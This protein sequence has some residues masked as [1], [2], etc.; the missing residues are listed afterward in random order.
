MNAQQAG[1]L[2]AAR[3]LFSGA[4]LSLANSAGTW[5]G[6]DFL[7]DMVRPGIGLYGGGPQ[8]KPDHDIR[9]VARFEA[10]ILDVR[11][12]P[13]GESVGYGATFTAAGPMRVAIVAAG[14]ADGI[15]RS[16]APGGAVWFAGEPRPLLGKVSMDLIALDVTGCEAAQPG[17]L[18]EIFGPNLMLDDAAAAA[19]TVS[20]EI[21][22]RISPR[23][24]R[25]Y[26][27]AAD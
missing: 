22:T 12:V 20:Y 4:R 11:A 2:K 5:L 1:R 19:G 17:A 16:A 21:L 13:Q 18:V 9:P 24:E 25:I 6:E 7:F 27:G 15:L 3:H 10:P 8:G 23:A 14:Y 26:L